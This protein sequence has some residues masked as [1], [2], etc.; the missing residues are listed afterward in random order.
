M[1]KILSKITV[2]LITMILILPSMVVATPMKAE[3]AEHPKVTGLYWE[4]DTYVGHWDA[5]D[6]PENP[7]SASYFITLYK[8]SSPILSGYSRQ[9]G[10]HDVT[11]LGG[12]IA[13]RFDMN[14]YM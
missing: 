8:G 12:Q 11:G 7:L 1:K 14:A 10:T 2:F 9:P 13:P 3:A 6:F 4:T 5:Y